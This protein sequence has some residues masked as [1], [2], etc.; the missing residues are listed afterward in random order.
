MFKRLYS[1]LKSYRHSNK[2]PFSLRDDYLI[3]KSILENGKLLPRPLGSLLNR[4]PHSISVR[5]SYQLLRDLKDHHLSAQEPTDE[6]ILEMLQNRVAQIE[7]ELD[8]KYAGGDVV[9]P[10]KKFTA[11]EDAAIVQGVER[12]GYDWDVIAM[13]CPGRAPYKIA[14]RYLNC[15][16]PKLVDARMPFTKEEDDALLSSVPALLNTMKRGLWQH[17]SLYV[18]PTRS[19]GQLQRRWTFTLDS[20]YDR[21]ALTLEEVDLLHQ[22]VKEHGADFV[23]ISQHLLPKR[24][25]VTLRIQWMRHLTKQ[26]KGLGKIAWT[27]QEDQKLIDAVSQFGTAFCWS[28]IRLQHFPTALDEGELSARYK[29]L[30]RKVPAFSQEIPKFEMDTTL[31]EAFERYGNDIALLSRETGICRETIRQRLAKLRKGDRAW[32][33]ADDCLLTDKISEMQQ[34]GNG[35][36]LWGEIA[37][38]LKRSRKDCLARWRCHLSPKSS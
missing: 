28:K 6:I 38:A 35:L 33:D 8:Q 24:H 25:P 4:N 12:Y 32:T 21:H 37:R 2:D 13:E 3:C 9:R 22:G 18:V 14:Y 16:N 31:Q 23:K 15:L 27:L 36:V 34:T 5:W 1:T 17:L 10:D 7:Q 11:Q 20:A 30:L 29:S 26:P 19:P